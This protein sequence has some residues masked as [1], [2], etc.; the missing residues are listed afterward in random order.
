M[1]CLYNVNHAVTIN[2]KEIEMKAPVKTEKSMRQ[3][4]AF[5]DLKK[6]VGVSTILD[7]GFKEMHEKFN[8]LYKDGMTPDELISVYKKA[9]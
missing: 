3:D 5:N 1:K 7:D 8:L 4:A 2:N 6:E 9:I